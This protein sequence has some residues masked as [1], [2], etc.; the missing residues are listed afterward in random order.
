M[1]DPYAEFQSEVLPNG[2]TIHA[3]HWPGRPWESMIF[4]IHSGAEQD[5]IGLEGL[6]HFVEHV[7]TE[8]AGIP[9]KDIGNFFKDCGGS[10]NFGLTGYPCVSY[11]F[12]VPA[13]EALLSRALSIFGQMLFSSKI[14]KSIERERE[15]IINEFR[16]FYSMQFKLNL[17][18]RER[19]ALYSDCWLGRFAGPFGAID[20]I[21]RITRNDLQSYYD[22]QYTPANM[23]IVAVGGKTLPELVRLIPGTPL[24][25]EKKGERTP[26]PAVTTHVG[27]PSEIRYVFRLSEHLRTEGLIEVG[28]Y[29]SVA[30]VPGSINSQIVRVASNMLY[31]VLTEEVRERRAWTYGINSSGHNFRRFHEVSINCGAF[32]LKAI[33]KIERVIEAC[34]ASIENREDLFEQVKRRVLAEAF[35]ADQSG[36]SVCGEAADDLIY[37]QRIISTKEY[38]DELKKVTMG[39]IR[40]FLQWLRPERRWTLI[41][42][43]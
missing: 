8:N 19:E 11:G 38:G 32:T 2:L 5:P 26:F 18:I 25:A 9:R 12:F 24:M 20:S 14:E 27:L 6:A 42:N 21:E 15:I 36:S 1:W 22:A 7:A 31:N 10:I 28:E 40:D 23:S 29:R 41:V 17:V 33:D 43:P 39:D 34:I 16:S 3:A 30:R 37:N 4:L 35:I 13:D